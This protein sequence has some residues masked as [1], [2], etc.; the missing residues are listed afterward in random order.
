MSTLHSLFSHP[1]LN[2]LIPCVSLFESFNNSFHEI[3]FSFWKNYTHLVHGMQQNQF[4]PLHS[5]D[6]SSLYTPQSTCSR[7]ARLH[8]YLAHAREWSPHKRTKLLNKLKFLQKQNFL[9]FN[10]CSSN[11][12]LDTVKLSTKSTCYKWV[13]FLLPLHSEYIEIPA[14]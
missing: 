2:F 4:A 13:L 7:T 3:H 1:T 5:A 8:S 10:N 9:F 14:W 11:S 6:V 12:F